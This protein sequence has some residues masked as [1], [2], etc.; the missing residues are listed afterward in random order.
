MLDETHLGHLG[1]K[2]GRMLKA[3]LASSSQYIASVPVIHG[4]IEKIDK[5]RKIVLTKEETQY[6]KAAKG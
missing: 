2:A 6:T 5:K 1:P 4:K 3:R